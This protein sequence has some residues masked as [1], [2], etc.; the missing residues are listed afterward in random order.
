M[1][2]V[3]RSFAACEFR[4]LVHRARRVGERSKRAPLLDALDAA[5]TAYEQWLADPSA[6]AAVRATV[7]GEDRGRKL[8]VFKY[9]PKNRYKIKNGH[10][11]TYTRLRIEGIDVG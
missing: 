7:L 9:K 10:R 4:R 3:A 11:Q 5:A 6:G 8:I 1:L 2:P